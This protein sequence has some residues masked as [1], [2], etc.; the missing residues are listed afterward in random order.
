MLR[1]LGICAAV[2]MAVAWSNGAAEANCAFAAQNA[3]WNNGKA[4][5][6]LTVT[7]NCPAAITCDVVMQGTGSDGQAA[8]DE[9]KR[10]GLKPGDAA[11]AKLTDVRSCGTWRWSC[12]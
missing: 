12:Q 6:S 1:S 10:V 9:R 7:N 8:T 5:C 2:A 3:F 11:A 4:T